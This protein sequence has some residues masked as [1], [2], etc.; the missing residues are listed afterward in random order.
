M[1]QPPMPPNQQYANQPAQYAQRKR[2]SVFRRLFSVM[3]VIVLLGSIFLNLVLLVALG[4]QGMG[5]VGGVAGGNMVENVIEPGSFDPSERIAVIT[6][7]GVVDQTMAD[8]ALD[9][10]AHLEESVPGAVVVRVNSPGG[11]PTASD[12]I[13]RRIEAFQADHGV[14]VVASFGA[15]AASGG[16]YLAAGCDQIVAEELSLTGSI[17]VITQAFT[18]EGTLEKLGMTPEVLVADGSPQKDVANTVMRSW[19]DADRDKVKMLLNHYYDAFVD[20]VAAGRAGKVNQTDLPTVCNGDIFTG[21]QALANGLVDELGYLEDA[22]ELARSSASLPADGGVVEIAK[23]K[24]FW[25]ELTGEAAFG[26]GS[27]DVSVDAS[28]LR[29]TVRELATPE[30]LYM[31]PFRA[32]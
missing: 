17:G 28:N 27:V 16:Y 2:S 25:E 10:F 15:I 26:I 14:P 12:E 21:E 19:G 29:Q 13:W 4:G 23:P 3:L 8:Y 5:G 20:R 22:I 30:V 6:L 32:G 9:A 24:T 18:F 31:A 1:N 11:S 7:E